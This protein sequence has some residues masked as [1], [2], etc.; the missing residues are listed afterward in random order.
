MG[1][2]EGQALG[3]RLRRRRLHDLD[4]HEL[5][6]HGLAQARNQGLE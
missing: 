5:R 3:R 4:P 6:R 1:L 2:H